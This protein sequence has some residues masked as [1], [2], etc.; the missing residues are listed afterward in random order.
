MAVSALREKLDGFQKKALL[1]G[2]LGLL[3]GGASFVFSSTL[4][5]RAYLVAYLFAI[6]VP[7][8][9]L[10]LTML[11]HMTGGAWGIAIRRLTE[12]SLRT[13]PL[14]AVLFLPVLAGLWFGD[15]YSWADPETVANDPLL[16]HKEIF[17]NKEFFTIRAAIYFALWIAMGLTLVKLAE[18]HDRTGEKKLVDRMRAIS[19][20]G[21]AIY[22]VTM[23]FA[24]FDW[25]MSL[26]PHW[27]S[28]IYGMIFVVG[29]V[30]TT[31]CFAIV[32]SSWLARREPFSR[33][34]KVDH[35]HD[36]G[37]LLFA[38]VM[39]WAYAALSQYLIIWS[40]NLAEETPW[41][42]RRTNENWRGVCLIL[43]GLHFFVPFLLLMSRKVKRVRSLLATIAFFL[44]FLRIVDM[45]W[46]VLPA[47][48]GGGWGLGLLSVVLTLGLL[49]LWFALLIRVAK[50]R[51]L[52]SLQDASLENLLDV[53]PGATS[54]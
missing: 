46:L 12:A 26:E 54:H 48:E 15:L 52:V 41:Y 23:T 30:L 35:F 3:L 39:L 10:G 32:A 1:L 21:L 53:Q 43:I 25:A 34:L 51:P 29:Q 27:F 31:L 33:F 49:G 11:H 36:L 17:L 14:M 50:G 22:G 28:T 2:V 19:G 38:F 7:L 8:G 47:Y 44:F 40:A 42:L 5:Y 9:S 20:P 6:S 24:A 4:F 16:Q 18:R 13:L 37:T 45:A